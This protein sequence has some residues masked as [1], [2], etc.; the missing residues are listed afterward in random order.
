VE[1]AWA[2]GVSADAA[3]ADLAALKQAVD[4]GDVPVPHTVLVTL[5]PGT[6]G[7]G[8]PQQAHT[9]LQQQLRLAQDWL[10]D[11]HFHNSR[12]V[13]VTRGAVAAAETEVSDLVHAG[14]WGLL[15]S[16]ATENPG[17]FLLLDTDQIPVPGSLLA[18][19][20][21]T[22]E[23]QI[24]LRDGRLLLPRLTRTN[25]H[26]SGDQHIDWARGTVL[27]TGATGT[28]GRLLAHHLVTRHNARSL[29]LLSRRGLNAPGATDLV[30]ELT[31]LGADV[32]VE[33]CDAADR[34]ALETVLADIPED[35]PLAAVIHTA[36]V[37]DD[38]IVAA[39]SAEQLASVLRPKIDAAWNLHELTQDSD[40]DAFVLYSSIAGLLGT[41]GQANYA[42]GNTF[43]DAL[44]EHRRSHGLA[45]VSLGWGLWAQSS[46][47]SGHLAEVDLKRMARS[48]LLPL[49]NEDGMALF[50]GAFTTGEAVLAASR[51]DTAALR[52]QGG[53]PPALLR[54]LVPAPV[55]RSTAPA[56]G[57]AGGA[58]LVERL[59]R[60][61]REEQQQALTEI[62][63]DHVADV[64]GHSGGGGVEAARA[65]KD[66]GFDS[67]TAVELRNRLNAATGL[68]L[69]TTLIY[70]H[71]NPAA[72]A[73]HLLGLLADDLSPAGGLLAEL[74]ALKARIGTVGGDEA[75][76]A[77]IVARLQEL[78]VA[79]SGAVP[80]AADAAA[81][82]DD[83]DAASDEELFALI[84]ELD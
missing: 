81:G 57:A 21:T 36:G 25:P 48:G 49:S 7:E 9:A 72:L 31:A 13:V 43:L 51:L 6:A 52:R 37:V 32:T 80:G 63:R 84:D 62:V 76:Q 23:P 33:A 10:A 20:L 29:L 67:L 59:A 8:L 4:D 12:L 41:A 44:A 28:L 54:G 22:D 69:P 18:T 1:A 34:T 15:R 26:D 2:L 70:D 60:L 50:D 46:E 45:G 71:P 65:F 30:E 42:A 17:R 56:E 11:E 35:R 16:A 27:I 40:L 24:A 78:L 73:A 58:S 14:V 53:E 82:H 19:A 3:Y 79:A 38:G 55:R 68:R 77:Q 74:D 64:L 83:L 5:A 66:L 39:M 61:S 47:L 75:A